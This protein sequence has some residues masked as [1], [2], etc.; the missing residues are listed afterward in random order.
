MARTVYLAALEPDTGKSVV[1]LGMMELLAGRV[2]RVGFFRPVVERRSTPDP[3]VQL[4]CERYPVP[5]EP[6]DLQGVTYDELHELTSAGR[7]DE[8]VGRVVERFR[9]IER[10]ATPSSSSAATSPT[11]RPRPSSP[12]TSGSRTT[13][14]P[15]CSRWSAGASKPVDDVVA[16]G[17]H[18]A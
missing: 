11:S 12:S 18:G 13:S 5:G 10:R 17:A 1:A 14:A 7:I 8:L 16:Y 9:A 6:A 15:R 2:E 4:M 3:L